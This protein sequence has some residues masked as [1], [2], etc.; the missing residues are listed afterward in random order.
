MG[1]ERKQM[2]HTTDPEKVAFGV[3]NILEDVGFVREG[4]GGGSIDHGQQ[5]LAQVLLKNGWLRVR[6]NLLG[7]SV[8]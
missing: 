3:D 2:R 8:N 6:S 4:F 1:N 7:H 5:T